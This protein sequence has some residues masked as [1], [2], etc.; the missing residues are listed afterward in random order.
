M[1]SS[2]EIFIGGKYLPAKMKNYYILY[3]GLIKK[4]NLYEMHSGDQQSEAF[5]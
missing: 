2:K 4:I 5:Q 1:F 3:E